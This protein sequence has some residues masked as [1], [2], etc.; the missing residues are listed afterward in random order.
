LQQPKVG[1]E[2]IG[3]MFF[4]LTQNYVAPQRCSRRTIVEAELVEADG[5]VG[6]RRGIRDLSAGADQLKARVDQARV[7]LVYV[8]LVGDT[9]HAHAAQRLAIPP[10][11][12]LDPL[13]LRAQ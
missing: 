11:D 6:G 5:R 8:R 10:P 2:N 12:V 4:P 9:R 7:Q 3:P 13:K 1:F